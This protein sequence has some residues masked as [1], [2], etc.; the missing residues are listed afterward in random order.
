MVLSLDWYGVQLWFNFWHTSVQL[1]FFPEIPD[2]ESSLEED[3]YSEDK[4]ESD[5]ENT[6]TIYDIANDF[7]LSN[8]GRS[9][10]FDDA[11]YFKDM[12]YKVPDRLS[13][14]QQILAKNNYSSLKGSPVPTSSCNVPNPLYFPLDKPTD[15]K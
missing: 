3:D 10:V 12:L 11:T 14:K 7:T 9:P 5:K 15:Y 13:L 8:D 1:Q 4:K 2:T 6:N